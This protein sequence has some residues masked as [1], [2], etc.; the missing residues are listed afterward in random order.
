MAKII[1][2]SN[3]KGGV[4]KTTTA[5]NLSSCL[6]FYGQK[7]LLVDM[8]PQG[9]STTGL[10]LDK[11][12]IS[13]SIYNVLL[14][15]I[16]INSVVHDTEMN[17]LDIVPSNIELIGAEVELVNMFSRE[18]KLEKAIR[19]I[20]SKYDFILLDNPPSLGLLTVNSL[21]ASDSVIVPIQCE[22]YAL[23]GLGQLL[24]T[25]KLVKDNLNPNLK[26]EG[27]VLTMHDVR[28]NL[29]SQVIDEVKKYFKDSIYQTIIPRNVR[30]S[31]APGFG[32]PI[33]LYSPNS[34][35]ANAY[36]QLA[37]EFLSRNNVYVGPVCMNTKE[38]NIPE[39]EI[40]RVPS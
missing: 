4:G 18:R 2:I 7:I 28:V 16:D 31:E 25:L 24:D 35:G 34:S 8:D 17:L 26:I 19:R 5:V 1:A 27:V 15:K 20:R 11:K 6:A 40:D 36:L 21:T 3:Q 39:P 12:N 29:S 13:Q 37:R 30:L 23:E 9:N 22:Y 38:K 32:K 14:E 33:V 10:G